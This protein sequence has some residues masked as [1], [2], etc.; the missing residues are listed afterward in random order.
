M[1]LDHVS[2]LEH[3]LKMGVL[4]G[5]GEDISFEVVI[6]S[7]ALLQVFQFWQDKQIIAFP[8]QQKSLDFGIALRGPTT[9][10]KRSASRL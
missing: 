9:V 2:N 5:N 4:G 6:F 10:R 8:M 1:L 7:Q 3:Q